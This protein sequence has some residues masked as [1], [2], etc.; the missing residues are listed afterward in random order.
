MKFDL[1]STYEPMGDQPEAIRTITDTLRSNHNHVVLWGVTGSGKTFT[2]A[3]A[4]AEMNKPILVL[5]HNKTLAAQ[6]YSEFKAFFPNNVVEY[7]VSYYDYFQPEAYIPASNTY[8]EKDLA[9]NEDLECMRLN[10]TSALISGRRDV[11]IVSSVS[12]IYGIGNPEDFNSSKIE[13]VVGECITHK[14][15]M[16]TLSTSLFNR[17]NGADFKRGE[18]RRKGEA[19][20]VYA[21]NGDVVFRIII[22]DDIVEELWTINP[23]TGVRE[24]EMENITIHP[25][26]IFITTQEKMT[27][28]LKNIEVDLVKRVD[29]LKEIGQGEEALRLKRRTESDLEMIKEIGYCKGI[30]NY[31]R[32]FD[33]RDE[34]SRPFCLLDYFPDDFIVFID[35]SHVTIPQLRGM[36]NGDFARKTNLVDYGWRLPS[37]LD[38]RPLKFSEFENIVNKVVYVSATPAEYEFAKSEGA[39]AEQHIRPTGLL[40]PLVEVRNNE[41]QIDIILEEIEKTAANDERILI[42]T[43]TKRMAEEL[44]IFLDSHGVRSRYIHSDIDNME[45]IEH[46]EDF[47]KGLFD[48][49]VGVNLLREGIDIPAV[50]LVMILDA[51]KEGFLRTETSLI[52]TAGRAA[53]NVNG[54][55]ILFARKETPAMRKMIKQT[56]VRRERQMEFN[57]LNNITP[58]GATSAS[59]GTRIVSSKQ[60]SKR[61]LGR[62][63]SVEAK[64]DP[65]NKEVNTIMYKELLTSSVGMVAEN[66]VE[67]KVDTVENLE[68]EFLE[69]KKRMTEFAK[70]LDFINAAEQR[71]LMNSLKERIENMGSKGKKKKR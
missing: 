68:Q 3:N 34:G 51:D 56:K 59:G 31:S 30:E 48:V 60:E 42:T 17:N 21:A 58:I 41:N 69:A 16:Q 24:S 38:N 63:G 61:D 18:Y 6:L 40:D 49:L 54:K 66:G 65:K 25:A 7:F 70:K 62:K 33:H 71:D 9:I 47:R 4:I 64:F 29:Y 11:I 52:Q 23:Q 2:M 32:Y 8:I 39:V 1:V 50:S 67:Y 44:H 14:K 5:S 45:R 46:L 10:A 22:I 26:S 35:E 19:I 57:R 36:Y 27:D 53:R 15:L 43:L 28:A 37:A 20:D 55:V 12:C 13:L